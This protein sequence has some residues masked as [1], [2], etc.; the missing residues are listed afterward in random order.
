MWTHLSRCRRIRK[1][2]TYFLK[3]TRQRKYARSVIWQNVY[4][5]CSNESFRLR[6]MSWRKSTRHTLRLDAW[7]WPLSSNRTK[8]LIYLS[9]SHNVGTTRVSLYS[10]VQRICYEF[11]CINSYVVRSRAYNIRIQS[12]ETRIS[13]LVAC[14]SCLIKI[15]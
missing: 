11:R 9:S 12:P 4:T 13:R 15:I 2:I 10:T 8:L 7:Y 5:V 3:R 14:I 1:I 6:E